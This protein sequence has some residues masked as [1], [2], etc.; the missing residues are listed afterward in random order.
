MG[1]NSWNKF[2]CNINENLIRA[3]ADALVETG[4]KDLG[5]DYLNLDDCW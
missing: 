4:L 5:Y 2:N 1:W 3:T